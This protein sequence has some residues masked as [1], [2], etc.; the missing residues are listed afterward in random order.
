MTNLGRMRSGD[1]VRGDIPP[2][3]GWF[4]GYSIPGGARRFDELPLDLLGA[5]LGARDSC[6]EGGGD[7]EIDGDGGAS[8][9]DVD[10]L[11]LP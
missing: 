11:L 6:S 2:E 1:A 9:A 10:P 3:L 5:G 7:I 8:E 4:V